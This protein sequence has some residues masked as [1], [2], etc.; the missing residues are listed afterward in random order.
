MDAFIQTWSLFHQTYITGWIVAV[1]LSL[2]GIVVVLRDQIFLGVSVAQASTVG[3]ALSLWI[4]AFLG[5]DREQ[6]SFF[7][8]LEAGAATFAAIAAVVPPILKGKSKLRLTVE[9]VNGWI[10]LA[11]GAAAILI[12]AKAPFGLHEVEQILSAGLLG[13]EWREVSLFG[14][15][16]AIT[17]VFVLLFRFR[18]LLGLLDAGFARSLGIG[19]WL[20]FFS[21]LWVGLMLGFSLRVA[22][23]IYTFGFLVLPAMSARELSKSPLQ[24][25][26]VAPLFALVSSALGFI[27]ASALDVPITHMAVFVAS[28]LAFF[29]FL[30]RFVAREGIP[31]PKKP[32]SAKQRDP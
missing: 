31:D 12:V 29:A 3:V 9:S 28:V 24:L 21:F 10:F 32:L 30:F 23:L 20:E 8:I 4:A 2:C 27:L 11:G 5:I 13:S 6:S 7:W 16:L 18:L 15:L 22:G 1:L 17:F 26:W 19:S 25:L 14:G